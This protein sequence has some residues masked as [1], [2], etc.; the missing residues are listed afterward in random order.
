M[1]VWLIVRTAT[2]MVF[3]IFLYGMF[4][5]RYLK[6]R[7]EKHGAAE[8]ESRLLG[9]AIGAVIFP[10]GFCVYGWTLTHSDYWLVPLA[11]TAIIG[12]G[13][14]LIRLPI[15]NYLVDAFGDYAASATAVSIIMEALA[16]TFVPLA[17]P[18][19]Y[20]NLG[21]GLGNGVIGLCAAFFIPVTIAA[22]KY[23]HLIRG[24]KRR[25]AD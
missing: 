9:M 21:Y 17:G 5:D 11:G 12:F 25:W 10:I 2:G 14:S 4:S 19:L 20:S 8:P 24:D 22:F 7:L 1:R 6:H 16:G 23:G 15:Q 13:T 3:G 18:P